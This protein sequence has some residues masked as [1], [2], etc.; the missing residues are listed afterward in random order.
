ML[1][2]VV[3][4]GTIL[5][6]FS[7]IRDSPIPESPQILNAVDEVNLAIDQILGFTIRY[8]GSILKVTGNFS[9]ARGLAQDYLY[10]EIKKVP[11]IHPDWGVSL[12]VGIPEL[13]AYWFSRNSYSN[14][15]LLLQYDLSGL[16]LY[17]ISY[18]SS[19][20]LTV[21]IENETS[22]NQARLTVTGNNGKPSTDLGRQNFGF[23][24]Y[25]YTGST[26]E[27]VNPERLTLTFT[28]GTYI[29]DIPEEVDSEFYVVQVE[30][31]RGLMVLSSSANYL[32]NTMNWS[33]PIS[34]RHYVDN[35]SSDLDSNGN[36]GSQSNFAAQQ[37]DPDSICDT[38]TE[39]LSNETQAAAYY[40]S[41]YNLLGSTQY[42]FG[43]TNDLQ[44]DNNVYMT[45]KSYEDPSCVLQYYNS[46]ETASQTT[47]SSYSDKVI[48]AFTPNL[49]GN[50]LIIASAEL[51][52][53]SNSYAIYA[54]MTI[55][56]TTYANPSWQ[57]DEA[58]MWESFYTSKVVNLDGSAHTMR[59]QYASGS[60]YQ[61]A[62]V[63]RARVIALY[64]SDFS[65]NEAESEQT[66]TSTSY[67]DIVTL[68]FTP[69]TAGAYLLVGTA[70]VEA[71]STSYSLSARLM[72]DGAAKDAMT[73]EGETT[74]DYEV[75]A[76]HNVTT[77][78]AAS[79]TMKI[80]AS[81]ETGGPTA[82]IRRARITA[83]R[84]S[85]H[86]DY[87]SS[88]SEGESS[89][90]STTWVDKTVLTFSPSTVGNYLIIATAKINLATAANGYQP[91]I[92]FTIDGT[93]KGCWQAGLSDTTDYLTFAVM[94]NSSLSA[95]SHTLKI[96]YKT[97]N[98][99]YAAYIKDAR[100]VALRGLD[101]QYVSEV[102][103]TGT[104]TNGSMARLAW[105]VDSKF[106][107]DNVSTTFQL[108]NY[109]VSAY[110]TSGDGFMTS[111][112]GASNATV[113]QTI[114][115]NPTY[116][117]DAA[118]GNWKMKIKAAKATIAQFNWSCDF[119]EYRLNY[120]MTSYI[121]DLEEQW[122]NVDYNGANG[123][124]AIY[125]GSG[126]NSRSLETSGGYMVVGSGTP[127]WGSVTGTISFWVKWDT[128][129]GRPWG[130]NSNM[131]IR[132]YGSNLVLDWGATSSITSNTNFI[133]GK[134]Y[135]IAIDWNENTDNLYLYV[136]D[137]NNP[138]A[139]DSHISPWYDTVSDEGVT[140]NNFMA[141]RGGVQPMD[142]HGDEL[143]YWNTARTLP[144]I[145]SDYKTELTGSEANLRSYFK[146]SN[147]FNDIGPNHNDGSGVAG[148]LF[149]ADVPFDAPG[150]GDPN[151]QIGVDVWNGTGW[152]NIFTDLVN[153]W[154][155]A[156]VS[157]FLQ[158]P[159]FT[160]RFIDGNETG[161]TVQNSW[162]IDAALLQLSRTDLYQKLQ[163][164]TVAIELLQNG[165]MQ[166]FGQKLS[167]VQARPV[168]PI[169]AKSFHMNQ[170]VGGIDREVP[171]QIE[172]WASDYRIPLGLSSNLSVF[173][174]KN[175]IVYLVTPQ[176]SSVTVWWNGSDEAVQTPYAYISANFTV[177][178]VQRTLNNGL[179]NL[180]IDY[181]T[182]AFRVISTAGSST[183]TSELWR[184]NSDVAAYGDAE[185]N[186][187][188]SR[189]PVR[190]VVH[191]EVEWGSGGPPNCKDVLAHLVLTLPA[192][193]TYYTYALR[194]M[195]LETSTTRT[196]T[197]LC[198]INLM[199][200]ISLIQTENG[201]AGGYPSV[202]NTT[203][204][205]YN[206]SQTVWAHHWSQ[207]ISGTKGAGIMLTDTDNRRLY[208]FDTGVAKTGA[209]KTDSSAK[210]I[211]LLP[212]TMSQV[213]LP[214]A[215][216]VTWRG[217]VVTFD[218]TTPIYK[219]DGGVKTGLWVTVEYPPSI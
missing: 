202:T 158:S 181:S 95:A 48:L 83:V 66:V 85:D 24:R 19:L 209:L 7:T 102:E 76:A 15:T 174:N 20:G 94:I 125:V 183:C 135:F 3:L 17:N 219:V 149:S 119:V 100:I 8:Y 144:Q 79:H 217:A 207:F 198:P 69:S 173:S 33:V 104:A 93:E 64:L 74:A 44:S 62:T 49:A 124:L 212:V 38:L 27:T 129:G 67:Q 203:G 114:T 61:T 113:A 215:F 54:R 190:I 131:E 182:G 18:R 120:T 140:Q 157:S 36:M 192:N 40:P 91:A 98:A 77:L 185:P 12:S 37:S 63:R 178:T 9:Y 14:G 82:R 46:S 118:S 11:N 161:D 150:G 16:G 187:A 139:E 159:N 169:P 206:L 99:G 208:V 5:V 136:G 162:Q 201:T 111:T 58:S 30:D 205:F 145:Q 196:I 216:D 127:N 43:S 70:E 92:N 51:S 168:P 107:T 52:G 50:Y 60:T 214:G 211:E 130:Q 65:A 96:A 210:K 57:P 13:R 188:I 132:M 166:W 148:Y 106:T 42:V 142:G 128:I 108:F 21:Q 81:I 87:Q 121:L 134:W 2:A 73:T 155:N 97:T 204:L 112:I 194:L 154:N 143:R 164:A 86:Y 184:I 195:F 35:N 84:L 110:P 186:Y 146:F 6:T 122:T 138:P 152:T 193:V 26:W 55:D 218:G 160:I 123:V 126:N 176:V 170:T 41:S 45:F 23:Y 117:R 172:D 191:H 115:I 31:Q 101:K 189:G 151:E 163:N 88:G 137:Q 156:P 175:M 90:T 72:I 103:F 4:V 213:S 22:A 28:N 34:S 47:S 200:S 59:V 71:A 179:L 177:D 116:F 141:S 53:S 32:S 165:T 109:N 133:S 25:N 197:D 29:I 68:T 80:Q 39:G 153:G 180:K 56:G 1:V 167:T 89:T 75:F 147:N 171:F 10:G 78:S 105:T 199:T